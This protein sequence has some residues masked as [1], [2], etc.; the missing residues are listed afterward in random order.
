VRTAGLQERVRQQVQRADLEE[1]LPLAASGDAQER[2]TELLDQ[3]CD[4][5]VATA[6]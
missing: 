3:V 4:D 5:P 6:A 2:L 1:P